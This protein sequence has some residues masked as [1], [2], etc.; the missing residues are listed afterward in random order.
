MLKYQLRGAIVSLDSSSPNQ[1]AEI[2]YQGLP[3][4]VAEIKRT[5]SSSYGAFGHLIGNSATPIDL[6]AAMKSER[7]KPYN[8][9]LMEGEDLVQKYDPEIPPGAIT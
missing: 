2:Q 5:L 7:M 9:K 3:A 4:T 1:S 8:P 6:D